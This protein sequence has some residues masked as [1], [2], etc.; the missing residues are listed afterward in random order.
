MISKRRDEIIL[1]KENISL[2]V[3][4]LIYWHKRIGNEN[5]KL[6]KMTEKRRREKEDYDYVSYVGNENRNSPGDTLILLSSPSYICFQ[7]FIQTKSNQFKTHNYIA[8]YTTCM[9]QNFIN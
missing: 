1:I 8:N 5:S 2:L 7:F 4:N 9:R 3:I 6:E